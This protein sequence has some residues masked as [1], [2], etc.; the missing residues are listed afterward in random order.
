MKKCR[1]CEENKELSEFHNWK[2]GKDGLSH[3]CK[4]CVCEDRKRYLKENGDRI[5]KRRKE[6]KK[7][8]PE[9]FRKSAHDDYQKHAESRKAKKKIYC[10][11]NRATINEKQ[12]KRNLENR[13][14]INEK[15]R[16]FWKSES[17]RS[18]GNEYYHRVKERDDAKI[19]ARNK[20]RY[21]VKTGKV[22]KPDICEKCFEKCAP[23]AHHEDY[24]QALIVIWVCAYC[25][26]KLHREE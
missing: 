6:I 18:Y 24:S 9:R 15:G 26:K 17:G 12:R 7:S 8:D 23:E 25:H 21:A 2:Q 4:C 1:K 5:R 22:V 20:L 11:K 10:D 13:A 14:K 3:Y 19:K 16:L